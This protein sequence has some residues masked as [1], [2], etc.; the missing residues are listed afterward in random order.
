MQMQEA[1]ADQQHGEGRDGGEKKTPETIEQVQHSNHQPISRK[2]G[3]RRVSENLIP[4]VSADLEL[5]TRPP[6]RHSALAAG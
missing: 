6:L 4:V 3:P 1:L 5:C 2:N